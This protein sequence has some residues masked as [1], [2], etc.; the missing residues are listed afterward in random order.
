MAGQVTIDW[1]NVQELHTSEKFAS[2]PKGVVLRGSEDASQV[3]QGTIEFKDQK[4]EVQPTPTAPAQTVAVADVANVVDEAK[5]E[6]TFHH[7]PFHRGWKGGATFGLSLTEATQKNQT[8]TT[9]LNMVRAVPAED[10]IDMRSRTIFDFNQAYGEVSQSGVPTVKTSLYHI[11]AEEDW[12]VSSRV[13][14]FGSAIFDHNFSQGLK[15]QQNY[16]IGVGLV[17]VKSDT[18]EFDVKGSVNFIDQRFDTAGLNKDL[19]GTVFGETYTQKFSSRI[20]FN[21]QGGFTPAW[22][23]TRA[24]SAFA[25]AGLT[26]PINTRLGITFG[27]LDSFLNDPPPHFKK[28]SVQ[29]TVGATYGFR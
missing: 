14:V 24:Y 19:V 16:G 1:S 3:P 27:A 10:W 22:N 21:E 20:L 28:N 13:F 17:I 2:V 9:A 18:R 11:G 6:R 23:D 7:Q 29:L 12:Y 25:N 26:L 15:L 4:L 5:F 8:Y